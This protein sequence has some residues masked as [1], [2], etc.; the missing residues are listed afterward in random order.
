MRRAKRVATVAIAV[1]GVPGLI[2][3]LPTPA[4]ASNGL[5]C[6]APGN[7]FDGN[8][9]PPSPSTGLIAGVGTDITSQVGG[10]CNTAPYYDAYAAWALIADSSRNRYAQSGYVWRNGL[11][12]QLH[13]FSQWTS[14]SHCGGGQCSVWDLGDSLASGSSHHYKTVYNTSC[15]PT[16][17]P[18]YEMYFDSHRLDYTTYDPY[19]SS[20]PAVDRW[21][22]PTSPQYSGEVT[23]FHDFVPGQSTNVHFGNTVAEVAFTWATQAYQPTNNAVNDGLGDSAHFGSTWSGPCGSGQ[24]CHDIWDHY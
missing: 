22:T 20:T 14:V 2:L 4:G 21:S 17:T 23:T 24:F 18:C 1:A 3:S 7:F 12:S 8:Y 11:D 19:S 6:G 16:G 5:P 9:T 15:P 13:P 10:F